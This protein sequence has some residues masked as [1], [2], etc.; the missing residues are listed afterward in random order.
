MARHVTKPRNL[1]S[2]TNEK[3]V[4]TACKISAK[5]ALV[6]MTRHVRMQE[7]KAQ[8]DLEKITESIIL[9]KKG[10]IDD[11]LRIR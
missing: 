6:Y 10:R 2:S 11:L 9:S 8:G 1:Q 3:P 4:M 7:M 5:N